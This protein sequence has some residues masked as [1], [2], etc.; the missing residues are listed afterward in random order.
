MRQMTTNVERP[1]YVMAKISVIIPVYNKK[2]YVAECIESIR[3]QT[4]PDKEIILVDDESTDGSGEICDRYAKED[5]CIK[6]IHQKNAGPTAACVAGMEAANGQYF[7]FVDSDDYLDQETLQSMAECLVGK[8]GEVVCCNHILE[9]QKNTEEVRSRIEPGIYEGRELQENIKDKLIGQE[10]KLIP[11]SRCMKLCERTIFEGN[12]KYYDYAVRFG[13]D[14]HLM[15]PAMQ[16][17]S[18]VVIMQDALF[19]HYRYVE[20]SIVHGYDKRIWDSTKRVIDSL[21]KSIQDMPAAEQRMAELDREYCYMLLYIL[22]NEL[23]NPNQ[24]YAKK[25]KEIFGDREVRRLIEKTP[26]SVSSKANKLMYFG[27]KHPN[28]AVIGFLRLLMKCYDR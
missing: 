5:S 26:I 3:R 10:Y 27:V 21:R 11:M 23:R 16:K 22:K 24:D 19:Y 13:D 6:V 4:Y 17:A 8:A 7:M 25:I 18:R 28:G 1:G 14:L 15:Y 9:K 20:G 12:G 2:E